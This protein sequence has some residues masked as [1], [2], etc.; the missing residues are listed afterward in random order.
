VVGET[1]PQFSL[2][3]PTVNKTA[4]V[5]SKAVPSKILISKETH[6][7]LEANSTNFV[8][9]DQLVFMKGIGDEMVYTV[10]KRRQFT[11]KM[12][13]K[14]N[15]NPNMNRGV[16]YRKRED[17]KRNA[18][19]GNEAKGRSKDGNYGRYDDEGGIMEP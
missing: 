2:I 3:G 17:Q 9:S 5:C 8:F 10:A 18:K 13:L 4:R 12:I 1:K 15:N 14:R 16:Q 6:K 19:G 11:T 7:A